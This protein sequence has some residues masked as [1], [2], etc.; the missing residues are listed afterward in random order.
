MIRRPPRSTLFPY[1]TLF[2]SRRGGPRLLR[3][4]GSGA[5]SRSGAHHATAPAAARGTG[6]A[7]AG[8]AARASGRAG[9]PLLHGDRDARGFRE[10][11]PRVSGAGGGTP[12]GRGGG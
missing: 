12:G 4:D 9:R 7:G 6:G 11:R 10:R 2:R 8:A 3:P 5:G 1:T